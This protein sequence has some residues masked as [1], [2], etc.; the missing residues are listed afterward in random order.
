MRLNEFGEVEIEE[1]N[2]GQSAVTEAL[3]LHHELNIPDSNVLE[4]MK[5]AQMSQPALPVQRFAAQTQVV[6]APPKPRP[7]NRWGW[8]LSL[9]TIALL[10]IGGM[11][12]FLVLTPPLP[13]NQILPV[14]TVQAE[15]CVNC[16]PAILATNP[17][18]LAIATATVS[19]V[20]ATPDLPAADY[21]LALK[22][23]FESDWVSAIARFEK[24]R[25]AK[26]TDYQELRPLLSRSYYELGLQLGQTKQAPEKI[27]AAFSAALD[28]QPDYPEAAQEKAVA[29][30]Y[31]AIQKTVADQNWAEALAK[32]GELEQI[33]PDY[34][35]LLTLK[36]QAHVGLGDQLQAQSK[37]KEALEEYSKAK[38]LPVANQTGL[39][40]KID[41][42]KILLAPT[43]TPSPRPQPTMTPTVVPTDTPVPTPARSCFS[44]FAPYNL[45]Q[46]QIED[47]PDEGS[48]AVTGIVVNRAGKGISGAL[49]RVSADGYS[50]NTRTDG[51][52]R[53]R[54]GGLGKGAWYI[55]VL[56]APTYTICASL[57]ATVRVSGKPGFTAGADFVETEP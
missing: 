18:S 17:P 36:Y 56:A 3:G 2:E 41:K 24:A 10:I 25:Q 47:L 40:E 54:L 45:N 21:D 37:L 8:K 49:V 7:T 34:L 44:N 30:K 12:A 20:T 9:V 31:L 39:Q 48:S 42:L 53:Y 5:Y 46:P 57:S 26:G 19:A 51:S 50:F 11:V 43:P 6:S 33:K 13:T 32:I 35:N 1:N 16:T 52:G 23:Y 38:A 4:Q 55:T 29:E 22:A 28:L 27:F 14:P 15:I